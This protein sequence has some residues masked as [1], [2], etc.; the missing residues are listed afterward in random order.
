MKSPD[1]QTTLLLLSLALPLPAVAATLRVPLDHGT[2]Q[3]AVDAAAAGDT[4]LVGPGE[5][6]ISAPISFGGKRITVRSES[7]PEET[8][9][10]MRDPPA[11]PRRASVVV[12]ESG[13]DETAVLRGLTLTG[14]QGSRPWEEP[15]LGGGGIL[16]LNASS[17]TVMECTISGNIADLG[18]GFY[19]EASS[20]PS[21]LDCII[22]GNTGGGVWCLFSSSPTI[23]RCTIAEND[24]PYS[25]EESPPLRAFT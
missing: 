2:V 15:E 8:V 25:D 14:G 9:I 22:S 12:F 13:E 18:G 11:D 5:Y 4:V 24:S 1:R 10:R 23:A 21:L 17:P 19:C 3:A 16:C 7:G 6:L 20:S